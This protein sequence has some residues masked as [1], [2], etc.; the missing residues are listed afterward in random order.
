MPKVCFSGT[1]KRDRRYMQAQAEEYGWDI[2]GWIGDG[3]DVLV[4]GS[5]TEH[6]TQ[7][8]TAARKKRIPIVREEEWPELMMTGDITDRGS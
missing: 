4:V 7:R 8:E 1:F 2:V 6:E 3:P 5:E